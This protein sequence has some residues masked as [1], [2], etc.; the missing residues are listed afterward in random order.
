MELLGGRKLREERYQHGHFESP[1]HKCLLSQPSIQE[2]VKCGSKDV[3]SLI[4]LVKKTF[5]VSGSGHDFYYLTYF[6]KK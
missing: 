3:F 1:L 6:R 5:D 2:N 4:D